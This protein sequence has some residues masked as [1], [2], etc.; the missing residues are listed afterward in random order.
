[1]PWEGIF[2][3][4]EVVIVKDID[5]Q[6]IQSKDLALVFGLSPRR[7]RQLTQEG[8]L[9]QVARGK[10]I[11]GEAVQ[12]YIAH[13][14]E[15]IRE[16]AKNVDPKDLQKE[17]TRLRKA[18]ADKAEL[19]V[20]E[21]QGKL[22]RAEDVEAEWTEMLSNF[23][24]KMLALPTKLAPMLAMQDDI[25]EVQAMLKAGIYEALQELSEYDPERIIAR[26][27]QTRR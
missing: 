1:M 20:A 4:L 17:L 3:A 10:Y 24:A 21:Y 9:P 27:R 14:Q 26:A 7:I 13:L 19:E 11:L 25:Q 23:R 2:G 6:A 8:V 22:H 18:Q 16:A 12:A 15:K 5:K